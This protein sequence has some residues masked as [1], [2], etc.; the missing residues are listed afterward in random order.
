[1]QRRSFLAVGLAW[2]PYH[3]PSVTLCDI[4]FQVLRY[5]HSDRRYLLIHGNE[6][7]ARDL[8]QTWM[9]THPGIAYLVTGTTRNVEIMGAKIDPNRL[10]S[11]SG[12]KASLEKLN[13][14]WNAGQIDL[15]LDHLDQHPRRTGK[16]SDAPAGRRD[17]R[18]PQQQRRLQRQRGTG[19]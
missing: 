2:W 17:H 5:S 18:P 6:T 10:F 13:P 12:A 4:P 8:L 15:I 16:A 7:T 19:R 9:F 3:H 11:R 14:F 1:M